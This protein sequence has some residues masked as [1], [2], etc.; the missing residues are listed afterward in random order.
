MGHVTEASVALD[1]S[2]GSALL[3][4]QEDL[5]RAHVSGVSI[6]AGEIRLV[7]SGTPRV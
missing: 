1:M 4:A 5:L 3:V 2:A 6:G 7:P